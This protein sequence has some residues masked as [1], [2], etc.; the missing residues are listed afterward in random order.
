MENQLATQSP[1]GLTLEGMEKYAK[2]FVASGYFSD[3]KSLSQGV[4]KI[5]AGAELGMTPFASM[6]NINI[7][8][9][10]PELAVGALS[11]LV[12]SSDRYDYLIKEW[13]NEHCVI[14]WYDLKN[15]GKEKPIGQ[16]SFDEAE[17]KAAGLAGKDNWKKWAKAMYFARALSQGARTYCPDVFSGSVYVTGELSDITVIEPNEPKPK[18]ETSTVATPESLNDKVNSLQNEGDSKYVGSI[19]GV[20]VL[21]NS[22]VPRDTVLMINENNIEQKASPAQVRMM[23]GLCKQVGLTKEAAHDYLHKLA[24]VESLNDATQDTASI[25]ITEL[26]L[27]VK[28]YKPDSDAAAA[29]KAIAES[30]AEPIKALTPEEAQ[31]VF[32]V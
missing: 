12:K 32:D 30:Q 22:T 28:N 1:A 29:D 7:I 14:E 20:P 5:M 17:A 4:V 9:G 13:D 3:M 21:T 18:V 27:Q 25:M 10:K 6:K 8:Q 2:Y 16:S 31:G 15:W 23:Y 24:G 26:N 19:D 11:G